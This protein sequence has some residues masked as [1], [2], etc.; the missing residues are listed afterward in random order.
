MRSSLVS[1]LAV[2][3]SYSLAPTVSLKVK[4][5]ILAQ[6][7][8]CRLAARTLRISISGNSICHYLYCSGKLQNVN[9]IIAGAQYYYILLIVFHVCEPS[10]QLRVSHDHVA[11]AVL[12]I[13]CSINLVCPSSPAVCVNT[14]PDGSYLSSVFFLVMSLR[15]LYRSAN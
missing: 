6:V 13:S 14:N 11:L 2:T 7:V 9:A 3:A 12:S 15:I 10:T 1:S 4:P 8:L 5:R